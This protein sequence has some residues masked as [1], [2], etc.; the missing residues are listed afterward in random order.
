MK[1]PPS[2][3][4]FMLV[5]GK[6]AGGDTHWKYLNFHKSKNPSA[7]TLRFFDITIKIGDIYILCPIIIDSLLR[8]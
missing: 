1:G 6:T 3:G 2:G 5:C 8:F 4:F 7:P